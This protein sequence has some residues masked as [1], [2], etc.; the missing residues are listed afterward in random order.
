MSTNLIVANIK[1]YETLEEGNF[2]IEKFLAHKDSL[3]ALTQKEIVICPPFT[4]LLSFSSAFLGTNI[5]I[6]AQNVSPFNEGAYTGEINAKQIK[7]FAEYVLIGHSERRKFFAETE[8]MLK[9]KTE[10]SLK[11]GLKPIF[12]VQ[13]KNAIIPQGVGVV[14]YEPV[15]AIGS[16]NP[17]T[18]ENADE[19]AEVLKSEN[20]YLVLY[21][22]SVTSE[23]VKNF[24][25]KAN[26][27]GVLVGGA[28]LDP[29]E[30]YKIIENA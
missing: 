5:K 15:F 19:L 20:D 4:L 29:E 9:K 6:G 22:G 12:L 8:D 13:G 24:T 14:A 1:S 28:S 11:N 21:G 16:G 27:N 17:D 25:S 2:W 3:S 30:F 26:I 23:N 7:D 18:P 10:I